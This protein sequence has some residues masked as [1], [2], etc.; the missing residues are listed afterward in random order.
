MFAFIPF[1][2]LCRVALSR[3]YGTLFYRCYHHLRYL[4][5]S[6]SFTDTVPNIERYFTR[7]R[8]LF[9]WYLQVSAVLFIII[10]LEAV[11]EDFSSYSFRIQSDTVYGT[12]RIDCITRKQPCIN[13]SGCEKEAEP[14]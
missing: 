1:L 8:Y 10:C 11:L 14:A 4:G 9:E 3:S 2:Q 6:K 12:L 13:D 5:L 7:P